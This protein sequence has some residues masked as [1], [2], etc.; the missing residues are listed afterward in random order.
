MKLKERIKTEA[1]NIVSEFIGEEL[2]QKLTHRS[3][4][5]KRPFNA[6]AAALK[7]TFAVWLRKLSSTGQ[8]VQPSLSARRTRRVKS[9][10]AERKFVLLLRV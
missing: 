3:D 9:R 10:R 8:R 1:A 2:S 7:E 4:E 5:L 6:Q